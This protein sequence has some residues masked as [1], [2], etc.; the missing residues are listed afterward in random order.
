[1]PLPKAKTELVG[2]KRTL[3]T[4]NETA[5]FIN[6]N[7]APEKLPLAKKF[8]QFCLSDAM[9]KD[10]S[11]VVSVPLAYDYTMTDAE[12][13][14]MTPF[15]RSIWAAKQSSNVVWPG[16]DTALYLANADGMLNSRNMWDSN[17]A[18]D[19]LYRYPIRYYKETNGASAQAYFN[20]IGTYYNSIL[21]H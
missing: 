12:Q 4:L 17:V 13:Q 11:E 8:L 19:G 2:Q 21:G 15:G 18:G 14:K 5:A 1:M 7:T 10:F 20:G 3:L 6:S 16:A 9:L